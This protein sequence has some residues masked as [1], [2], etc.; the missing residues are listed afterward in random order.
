MPSTDS[1]ALHRCLSV[2][3]ERRPKA[4]E[5]VRAILGMLTSSE[6]TSST[7]GSQSGTSGV[8]GLPT[9]QAASAS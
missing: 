7:L 3:P 1:A 4:A 8:P 6:T 9:N 5:L 2:L